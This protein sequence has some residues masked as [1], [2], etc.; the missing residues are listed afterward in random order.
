MLEEELHETHFGVSKMKALA[1]SYI[2]WPQMDAEI[3]E[4]VKTCSDS[5]ATRSS[6]PVAPLHPWEWPAQPWS[7]IHI[8]F[9]GPFKGHMFLVLVD[10]HS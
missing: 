5:Q 10:A 2:W 8:D 3:E 7:R 1:R 9:A 6:P 4:T